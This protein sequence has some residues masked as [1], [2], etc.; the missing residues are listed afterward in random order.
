LRERERERAEAHLLGQLIRGDGERSELGQHH[1][2]VRLLLLGLCI[3][4]ETTLHTDAQDGG[5]LLGWL[6]ALLL[7]LLWFLLLLLVSRCTTRWY[8]I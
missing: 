1:E 6:F 2:S 5:L 3:A 7:L 8:D 4:F